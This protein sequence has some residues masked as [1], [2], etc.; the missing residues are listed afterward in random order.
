M[1]EKQKKMTAM[2]L[3]EA[4]AVT[5]GDDFIPGWTGTYRTVTG[6]QNYLA[7]RREP[8]YDERNEI[9]KMYN[10][11]QVQIAGGRYQGPDGRVYIKVYSPKF[12][13]EGFANEQFLR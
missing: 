7:L 10:G 6:T 9:G 4:E 13:C 2:N 11:E 8:N 5:G 12:G 1:E 3:E